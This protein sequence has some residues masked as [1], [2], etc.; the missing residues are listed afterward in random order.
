VAISI[1]EFAIASPASAIV[2]DYFATVDCTSDPGLEYVVVEDSVPGNHAV[3]ETVVVAAINAQD[4]GADDV[5]FYSSRGP[6]TVAFP[7]PQV[8]RVPNVSATDCVATQTG[9]L[10]HFSNPFCGTSAAAPHMAGIAALLIQRNSALTSSQLHG[11]LTGTAVDVGFPGYDFVAGFGRSDAVRAA[12]G[13]APGGPVLFS[14]ILPASRAVPPGATATAFLTVLNAG[15]TAATGVRTLSGYPLPVTMAVTETDPT[16]NLPIG[17]PNAA[18]DVPAGGRKT[19]VLALTPTADL[20]PTDVPVNVIGT[21]SGPA[22]TLTGINT[23]LLSAAGGV[24]DVVALSA[25][26]TADGIV[27]VPGVGGTGAF[28]VATVN[29]GAGGPVTATVD[30]GSASLPLSPFVCQTNPATGEC[31]AGLATSVATTIGTGE[32]P[33]FAVFVVA[34][35]RLS[36]DPA[37]HR[38]FIR[39]RDASGVVRGATSVAVQIL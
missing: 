25:T 4:P 10:G 3:E 2:F 38:V 22:P 33:T 6:T 17:A 1:L 11:L 24:P 36:F 31:L 13:A 18:V 5:A 37:V 27:R 28:S 30:T 23:L 7:A 20:A 29:V 39:F 26:P 32:T 14:A 34:G 16:T 8:R 21:N 35:G 12:E 9:A 19:F 15:G